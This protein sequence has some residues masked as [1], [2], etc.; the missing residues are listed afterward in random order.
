MNRS[1][2]K[3]ETRLQ[4][5]AALIDE[6][7]LENVVIGISA[8]GWI[9]SIEGADDA[10]EVDHVYDQVALPGMPNVHSHAFQRA[11]AGLSEYRTA[12]QDSFWTWRSLMYDFLLKLTPEDMYVIARQL[13]L[14]MLLAGYTWVGE[15]HYVHN[16]RDGFRYSNLAELSDAIVRAANDTGIGLCMLPVLY[17]RGGF[18]D[19]KLSG[20]QKRFELSNEEFLALFEHLSKISKTNEENFSLGIALHSLRAVSVE[21]AKSVIES[22]NHGGP[23]HIHVAEQTQE[24]DDCQQAHG[25][26]SVA[27]LLDNFDV[28]EQWC[29]IHATHLDDDELKRIASSNAVVGLCPTTEA[30]LGD[31]I[32]R[33][34]EFLAA[35]GRVSIGSDSHCSIDFKDELRMLEYGQRLQ[36]RQ[37]AILGTNTASVGRNLYKKAAINGGQAIGVK[38]GLLKVGYRADMVLVDQNHP[39]IA[40]ASGDRLLD[41]LLFCNADDPIVATIVGGKEISMDDPEVQELV[42][43]SQQEFNELNQRLLS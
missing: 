17:Q 39:A 23:I 12:E 38:T 43:Q 5:A 34:Q 19:S 24:I 33:A 28:N 31:G 7:W 13:Y 9:T 41:R 42:W 18:D 2:K 32:F 40:G 26:R 30:N 10:T 14:E 4:F 11:F 35:D 20:G 6:Q 16:E 37:R 27:F 25:Q 36:H 3:T 29:L 22:V 1:D 15:F 8:D 21:A